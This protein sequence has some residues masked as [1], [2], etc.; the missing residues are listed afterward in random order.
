MGL[1]NKLTIPALMACIMD[2]L[3][4]LAVLIIDLS[5]MDIT[6]ATKDD[7]IIALVNSTA[8]IFDKLAVDLAG[9][10]FAETSV[11]TREK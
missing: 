4:P 9:A 5:I 7:D 3:L 1:L 8:K 2:G 10:V 11:M 6:G